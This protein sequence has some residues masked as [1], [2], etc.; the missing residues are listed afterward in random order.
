M[1]QLLSQK[2]RK[3]FAKNRPKNTLI[4]TIT[5]KYTQYDP[6]ARR[7]IVRANP[8]YN[9]LKG[10]LPNNED[11][12]YT[13]IDRSFGITTGTN[14][15]CMKEVRDE[16][17]VLKNRYK[18]IDH[19]NKVKEGRLVEVINEYH[20]KE[21]FQKMEKEGI[22]WKQ[23]VDHMIDDTGFK[24]R[25]IKDLVISHCLPLPL[26]DYSLMQMFNNHAVVFTNAGTG[27]TK[28]YTRAGY[29]PASDFSFPGL[30][31]TADKDSVKIGVLQGTG[32]LVLDEVTSR[33]TSKSSHNDNIV[34]H[35][36]NYLEQG[37]I[38]RR[39]VSTIE[40]KGTK[41]IVF[42][43]NC[44]PVNPDADD[45]RRSI[46]TISKEGLLERVG[47]R[48]SH[49]LFGSDFKKVVAQLPDDYVIN[50]IRLMLSSA[51]KQNEAKIN[52]MIKKAIKDWIQKNDREYTDKIFLFT[53]YCKDSSTRDF[54]IGNAKDAVP[55][56]KMAG[57]KKAIIENL[58]VITMNSG[59]MKSYR[60]VLDEAK[61]NYEDFKEC[62]YKS[63]EYFVSE[64]KMKFEEMHKAGLDKESIEQKLR[65]SQWTYYEWKKELEDVENK[66]HNY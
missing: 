12:K 27:K 33:Q 37:E 11:N 8:L 13:L 14:A 3:F 28:T 54:M 53:K 50:N 21:L 40:L 57:M 43:G 63:F 48:I 17:E 45:F 4:V 10:H 30:V 16:Q 18:K 31:G 52:P 25:R 59:Y 46:S 1:K 24:D 60:K 22:S 55:K 66:S 58:D 9:V 36:L 56:L 38:D 29:K 32:T 42:L 35:L 49:V 41:A 62:N 15:Y 7:G 5:N 51:I 6:I 39:I 64:R 34:D 44:P 23:A 2:H 20:M 19:L 47:R 26:Q 61:K 65:I